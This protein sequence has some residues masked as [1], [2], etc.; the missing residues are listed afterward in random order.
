MIKTEYG[1]LRLR[2]SKQNLYA[3][4][5]VI[6]GYLFMKSIMTPDD[7]HRLIDAVSTICAETVTPPLSGTVGEAEI[8]TE[9]AKENTNADRLGELIKKIKRMIDQAID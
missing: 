9:K 6:I 5:S 2:G 3:D 4:L 8:K 7:I 1:S